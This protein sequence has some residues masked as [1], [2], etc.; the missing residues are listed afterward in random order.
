MKGIYLFICTAIQK[1][2]DDRYKAAAKDIYTNTNSI[3]YLKE[4]SETL[5]YYSSAAGWYN[6]SHSYTVSTAG[7]YCIYY[8]GSATSTSIGGNVKTVGTRCYLSNAS[9]GDVFSVAYSRQTSA[10]FSDVTIE[11][12]MLVVYMG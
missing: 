1:I 2:Y 3:A 11:L 8:W 10:S 12:A 4:S 7:I 5:N 9:S 6:I